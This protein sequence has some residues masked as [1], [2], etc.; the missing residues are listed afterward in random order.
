MKKEPSA[1]EET[2]GLDETDAESEECHRK[3]CLEC[4]L[5][6]KFSLT[7]LGYFSS[8]TRLYSYIS[9]GSQCIQPAADV[10]LDAS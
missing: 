1:K 6:L 3:M 10:H 5:R 8:L 2:F 9:K 7:F 4:F